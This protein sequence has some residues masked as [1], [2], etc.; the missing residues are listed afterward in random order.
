M[1]R[2]PEVNTFDFDENQID[3]QIV[4]CFFFH[5]DF[6]NSRY[7]SFFLLYTALFCAQRSTK[8]PNKGTKRAAG[9]SVHFFGP[10]KKDNKPNENQ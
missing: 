10:I 4:F 9:P 5:I 8:G 2:L 7:S 1:V 3:D 6:L